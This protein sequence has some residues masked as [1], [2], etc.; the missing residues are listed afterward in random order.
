MNVKD[1]TIWFMIFLYSSVFFFSFSSTLLLGFQYWLGSTL[2]LWKTFFLPN[3]PFYSK[4]FIFHIWFSSLHVSKSTELLHTGWIW[5]PSM[6]AYAI[7]M[8]H[9]FNGQWLTRHAFMHI[10][11]D[12]TTSNFFDIKLSLR[13]ITTTCYPFATVYMRYP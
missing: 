2:S 3:F 6:A 9:C 4:D 1:R 12:I 7:H 10:V 8:Y 11:V 13:V 5:I